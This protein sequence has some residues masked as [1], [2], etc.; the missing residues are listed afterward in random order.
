MSRR[1]PLTRGMVAIV[2]DADFDALSAYNWKA[3]WNPR[4]RSFYAAR[5]GRSGDGKRVTIRMSREI[6]KVPRGVL[7][8]HWNHDTLDNQRHNLR[9]ATT[10]Q[11]TQNSA[12]RSDNKS[13][14]RGVYFHRRLGKWHA[15]IKAHGKRISLGFYATK[16]QAAEAYEEAAKQYFG[17]FYYAPQKEDQPHAD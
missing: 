16:E 4:N 3:H 6:L 13:G 11:N 17:E 14:F 15:Q 12:I 1:I 2:D 10:S 7:V 9:P 5:N 8:D